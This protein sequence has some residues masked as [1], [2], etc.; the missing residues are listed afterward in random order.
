MIIKAYLIGSA[1]HGGQ[2]STAVPEV[3]VSGVLADKVLASANNASGQP[4]YKTKGTPK[5]NVC[6]YLETQD[7][8]VY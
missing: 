3:L 7:N 4:D 2:E 5:C 6:M 1:L 8:T